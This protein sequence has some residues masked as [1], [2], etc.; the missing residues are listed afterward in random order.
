MRA[1]ATPCSAGATA[2]SR[3]AA[4]TYWA[5]KE[6]GEMKLPMKPEAREINGLLDRV[7]A[8]TSE[9]ER[10]KLLVALREYCAGAGD[11]LDLLLVNRSLT[12][13]TGLREARQTLELMQARLEE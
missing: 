7:E 2:R 12:A 10:K 4:F 13:R 1:C 5:S 11:Q 8:T 3:R 9:A 6:K